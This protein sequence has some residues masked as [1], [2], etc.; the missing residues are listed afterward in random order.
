M[1]LWKLHIVAVNIVYRI[2]SSVERKKFLPGLTI[3][4]IRRNLPR[5][6][7]NKRD[8]SFQIE[9]SGATD[10]RTGEE[11]FVVLPVST[12]NPI[13]LIR[14]DTL[15]LRFSINHMTSKSYSTLPA[16]PQSVRNIF[17]NSTVCKRNQ[18]GDLSTSLFSCVW[19]T[20]SSIINQFDEVWANM[21]MSAVKDAWLEVIESTKHWCKFGRIRYS[22]MR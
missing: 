7:I 8:E 3:C 21:I 2:G 18:G 19:S 22:R 10:S 6:K 20:D 17:D 14:F 5:S 13:F 11:A 15:I 4:T 16:F 9:R 12:F 1:K